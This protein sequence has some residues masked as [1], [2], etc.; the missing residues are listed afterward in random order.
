[1]EGEGF[2]V[3]SENYRNTSREA[4]KTHTYSPSEFRLS[5]TAIG[6]PPIYA[7]TSQSDEGGSHAIGAKLYKH[8]DVIFERE[9]RHRIG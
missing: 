8:E 4:R 7:A 2:C 5:S 1:M 3:N 9:Q 6:E